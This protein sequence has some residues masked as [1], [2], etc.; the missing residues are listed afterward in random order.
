MNNSEL[1]SR[2]SQIVLQ[3]VAIYGGLAT[4]LLFALFL[5]FWLKEPRRLINGILFT[6]FFVAFLA[7]LA[8]MIFSTANIPFIVIMG[9]IFVLLMLAL[10]AVSLF[11]WALLLWNAWI[12][13]RRESHTLANMLTLL[14]GLFLIGLWVVNLFMA[15]HSKFLPDW[16]NALLS[17]LPMIGAYLGLCSFNFLVNLILY[18]FVPK[19]YRA[20]YLIVLGAGLIDGN[21]VSRL[22]GARID[23]A[24][25]FANKQIA[26]GRP[27]PKIIFSGGQGPDEKLSEA[28]AMA[29]YA[30]AHGWD[31]ELVVLEDKSRNT[32]ENMKFSKA[33]IDADHS[34]SKP[35]VR[36]F[37]N[38]YHTFRAGIYARMAGLPANGVGAAT[39]MY[40]LPNAIIR[41]F[42]AVFLMNKKRHMIWIL[43]IFLL[44]SVLLA[45]FS[46]YSNGWSASALPF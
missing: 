29:D 3:Q 19:R 37:S 27:A 32:L 13:W 24:I 22:L 10:A 5:Y 35:N 31:P 28:Q 30:I 43:I 41:E 34:V 38:N 12:V 39:R 1:V 36:F 11:A 46:V 8:V 17:G 16:V 42:V 7:E 21:Q 2:S 4:I 33:I 25:R 18:Q 26:K 40:F 20:N 15:S 9:T 23:R 44:F 14:L 6:V 45:G